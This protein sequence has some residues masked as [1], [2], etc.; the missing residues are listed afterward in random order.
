MTNI[1]VEDEKRIIG[2]GEHPEWAE[3]AEELKCGRLCCSTGA[4]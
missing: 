4:C 1:W 2:F 3:E